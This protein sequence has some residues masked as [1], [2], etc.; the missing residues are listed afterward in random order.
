M[1]LVGA[2]QGCGHKAEKSASVSELAPRIVKVKVAPLT[3]QPV[4]RTVEVVGTLRGWEDV[5]IGSK[6]TGRVAQVHHDMGDRLKPGEILV[7]LESVDADL[8]VVQAEKRLL[9]E[10]A[11][12][13]LHE[14]PSANFDVTAV[15]SVVEAKVKIDRARQNLTREKSLVQRNAGTAQDMQNAESD[16]KAAEA[17]LD[18]AVLSTQSTLAN[19]LA[20]KTALELA[21]QVCIDMEIHAPIPSKQPP[22]HQGPLEYAVGKRSVSEGQMVREGDPIIQLVMEDPL[23]LWTNV[24]ERF[25]SEV[26]LGQ[27]VR[28][29]IASSPNDVFTGKVARINPAVDAVSRTFQV[30]TV[31]SNPKGLLRPG[32][33]AKAS[34]LTNRQDRAATVSQTSIVRFAGVTKIFVVEGNKVRA[35]NVATGLEGP[36]WVEVIG[37]LPDEA[38]VVTDGYT[39]LA[40]GS[41]I[42]VT[43]AEPAEGTTDTKAASQ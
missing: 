27:D 39:Q 15:P 35:I 12:L 9:V 14:M 30:E 7:N 22:G 40:D 34:I 11:K 43:A 23:R 10:L 8:N 13:G 36:G 20:S 42:E 17:S 33:F 6:R 29:H 18:I 25:S 28:I 2:A 32:G 38:M 26:E 3:Y 41:L 4:E 19:T 37:Q 5:T 16:L 21:R 31:V 1:V 24:P